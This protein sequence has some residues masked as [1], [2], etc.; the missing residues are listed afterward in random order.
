MTG[1][2]FKVGDLARVVVTSGPHS[3][4]HLGGVV[5]IAEVNAANLDGETIDYATSC[6]CVKWSR[7]CGLYDWQLQPI[8][9]PTEPASLTR[10]GECGVEA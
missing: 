1:L 2:R 5:E 8:N 3:Q 7:G 9:P 10:S 6:D 4:L